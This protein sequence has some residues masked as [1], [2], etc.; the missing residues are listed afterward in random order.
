MSFS[1]GPRYK[2]N[3]QIPFP[4]S[5]ASRSASAEKHWRLFENRMLLA[6][7]SSAPVG[8][9]VGFRNGHRFVLSRETEP[10]HA[11]LPLSH[12][13]EAHR[14]FEARQHF[15]KIVLTP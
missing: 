9:R 1:A 6:D 11:T 7:K 15:G 4:K 5:R 2:T 10:I 8:E 14:S 12:V 13:Q 3:A